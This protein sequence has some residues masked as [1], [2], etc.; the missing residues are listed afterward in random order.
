MSDPAKVSRRPAKRVLCWRVGGRGI[1]LRTK[2]SA[3]LRER[4]DR[5]AEEDKH[6]VIVLCDSFIKAND[7]LV[8]YPLS[9][10]FVH[11]GFT[12]VMNVDQKIFLTVALL[13]NFPRGRG[14]DEFIF[15]W[16][17]DGLEDPAVLRRFVA[18][19]VP[20]MTNPLTKHYVIPDEAQMKYI[21]S[22]YVKEEIKT[23][24]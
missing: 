11:D 2:M 4:L 22:Q 20:I 6:I 13:E 24:V 16:G 5:A 14:E 18:R 17:K 7:V 21:L 3:L 8:W 19:A 9:C 10:K 1:I 23:D 12:E 15:V